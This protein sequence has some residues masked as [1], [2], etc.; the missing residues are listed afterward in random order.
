MKYFKFTYRIGLDATNSEQKYGEPNLAALFAGTPNDDQGNFNGK[1][2]KVMEEM[3][4]R[5]ELNQD[6]LVTFSMP[7]SDFDINA[8]VGG[9]FNE[10][11]YSSMTST[12]TGLDIPTW[13]HLSN[14]SIRVLQVVLYSANCLMKI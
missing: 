8:L 4:R 10:R 3:L 12:V 11:K 7:V 1:N 14:S 6:V 9:N 13:Y 2:G 5:R